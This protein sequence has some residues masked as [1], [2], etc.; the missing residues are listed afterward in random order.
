MF[1]RRARFGLDAAR[2]SSAVVS[3]LWR[4]LSVTSA[5]RSHQLGRGLG[6]VL[7][8]GDTRRLVTTTGLHSRMSA[9]LWTSGFEADT[10]FYAADSN[11]A[12][13]PTVETSALCDGEGLVPI[14]SGT[15]VA[16]DAVVGR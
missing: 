2:Y 9:A 7:V 5:A 13:P 15:G 8:D 10:P 11:A 1:G 12:C 4:V 3:S 14:C 6:T 16:R